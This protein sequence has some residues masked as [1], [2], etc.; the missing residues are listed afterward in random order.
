MIRSFI[1]AM[2]MYSRIPMPQFAWKDK[3]LRYAICFFPAVGLVIAAAEY[4][5]LYLAWKFSLG[6][7]AEVLV[8]AAIPLLVTGGIHADGFIDTSDAWQSYEGRERKLE[9]LKDPHIGAF[10]VIRFAVF[11][12]LYL[13]AASVAIREMNH[14]QAVLLCLSFAESRMFSGFAAVTLPN[15]RGEGMLYSFAGKETDPKLIAIMCCE[16]LALAL[17][18]MVLDPLHGGFL[19]VSAL[20]VF[21]YYKWKAEKE[22][23]GITGDLE[24][25]FLCLLELTFA[26]VT[27]LCAL[28]IPS[29]PLL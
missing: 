20:L 4:L 3:D 9:I 16:M 1:I 11:G 23:G 27:V 2:S 28:F 8:F 29:I 15:A 26:V 12:L 21:G 18:M 5:W 19:W 14:T 22:L 17:G 24:G 25:W 13:A 6:D 7:I 10:G